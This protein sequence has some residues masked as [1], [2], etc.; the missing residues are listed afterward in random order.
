MQEQVRTVPGELRAIVKVEDCCD[1][2]TII[3]MDLHRVR[4]MERTKRISENERDM[5]DG[6]YPY[7]LL[8][9]QFASL[10]SVDN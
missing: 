3:I 1:C 7:Q 2:Y 10:S 9:L 6:I 5:F 8:Q 4:E